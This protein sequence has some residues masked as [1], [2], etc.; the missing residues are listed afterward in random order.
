MGECQMKYFRQIVFGLAIF[1]PSVCHANMSGCPWLNQ[2]T[3][4]GVLDD[5][6]HVS[7]IN[8]S[9]G[10]TICRF[11]TEQDNP[12]H[13]LLIEVETMKNV[14][15]EFVAYKAAQ[16][17]ASITAL[18]AIGNEAYLCPVEEKKGNIQSV[19][20]ESV[21]GRVRDRAFIVTLSVGTDSNPSIKKE[22]IEKKVQQV[23]EQVAGALF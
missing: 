11:Y 12:P 14:S 5:P 22:D 7:V 1:F 6:V 15:A 8:G 3:A 16:C 13:S 4:V 2:A 10:N 21:I 19:Q 18:Q 23:A 9:M 17:N 20:R